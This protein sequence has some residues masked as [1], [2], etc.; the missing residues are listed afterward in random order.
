M[1]VGGGRPAAAGAG[2]SG[3][4]HGPD[5]HGRPHRG[6]RPGHH[7]IRQP[8]R[9]RTVRGL[10]LSS[11]RASAAARSAR[12]GAAQRARAAPRS[13]DRRRPDSLARSIWPSRSRPTNLR[14][15]PRRGRCRCCSH[16]TGA[17]RRVRPSP[18]WHARSA[19]R[20]APCSVSAR[21]VYGYGPATLRRILRFRRAVR[22]LGDGAAVRQRWQL[23]PGMPTSRT[24]TARSA[25]SP[26]CRWRRCVRTQQREQ[27]H[28]VAVRVGDRRITHAPRRIVRRQ[29]PGMPCGRD[30]FE[31][32]VDLRRGTHPERERQSARRRCR[33]RPARMHA[34][35]RLLGVERQRVAAGQL[36][37]DVRLLRLGDGQAEQAVEVQ[38]SLHVASEDL[39]DGRCQANIHDATLGR[40]ALSLS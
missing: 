35:D 38:R 4:V 32:R 39:E 27:V 12:V 23:A 1:R 7:R 17:W 3:R 16:V 10:A 25:N 9:R 30:L 28:P 21:A 29:R 6:G 8:T 22:L 40:P 37:R 11:R 14:P 20:A 18:T 36:H 2:A 13:A 31:Q 24:C 26:E 34:G 19:G 5:A 15:R 33:R